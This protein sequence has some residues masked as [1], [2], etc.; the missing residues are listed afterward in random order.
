MT[1]KSSNFQFTNEVTEFAK[2][3]GQLTPDKYTHVPSVGDTVMLNLDFL[4]LEVSPGVILKIID[5]DKILV[6]TK[7]GQ[8]RWSCIHRINAEKKAKAER[9]AFG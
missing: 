5:S 4:G 2:T 9:D 6:T 3:L 1:S 8:K 7:G